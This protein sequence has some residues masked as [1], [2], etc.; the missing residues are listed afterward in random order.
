MLPSELTPLSSPS[1]EVQCGFP[2]C[3]ADWCSSLKSWMPAWGLTP[4]L[5]PFPAFSPSWSH[6]DNSSQPWLWAPVWFQTWKENFSIIMMAISYSSQVKTEKLAV[7]LE[8]SWLCLTLLSL[9]SSCI[10]SEAK[11]LQWATSCGSSA[12]CSS[13]ATDTCWVCGAAFGSAIR[14][15]FK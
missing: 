7:W 10:K 3:C 8:W 15:S 2:G 12:V 13:Q 4:L 11:L 5:S 14:V 9:R 6:A 1:L